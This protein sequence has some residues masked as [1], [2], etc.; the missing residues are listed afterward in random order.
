METRNL[1]KAKNVLGRPLECCCLSPCTGFYR[2]GFCKT[3]TYDTGRHVICAQMTE[4]FLKFTK[5]KNNDL[6]TPR[7][8]FDFPG[9]KEGDRWCLC[10]L[11]WREALQA[12]VAPPVILKACHIN[13]LE[14]VSLKQLTTYAIKASH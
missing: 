11:R 12:G 4:P 1:V 14:F 2:D 10:V 8:E 5:S 3:D 13:A 9:L 6:T 7:E